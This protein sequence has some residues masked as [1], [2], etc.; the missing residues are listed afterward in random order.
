MTRIQNTP[1]LAIN[2]NRKLALSIAEAALD[3]IDTASIISSSISL[4]GNILR[5]QGESFDLAQFKKIKVIGFGKASCEAAHALEKILG[6]KI[7]QGVVVGLKSIKCDYIETFAGTHPTPAFQ[8]IEIGRKVFEMSTGSTEE[9]LVIVIVSGGGSSLLCWPEEECEQEVRLYNA[10]SKHGENINELNTIRKHISHLKGGGLAKILFPAT[11]IGLIFSDVPGNHFE[12]V[13]SGPTYKDTTTIADAKKLID[14]YNLGDFNLIETPK[15]D[16]FFK[17]VSNFVLVSNV[18]ALDAM[19]K[20]AE[21]LGFSVEILSSELY[22]EAKVVVQKIYEKRKSNTVIL[23]G[24]EPKVTGDKT[25]GSGGRCLFMGIN[26]LDTLAASPKQDSVFIFLASDGIDNSLSAGVV[27]DDDTLTKSVQQK[28]DRADHIRRF[29][30]YV[31]FEKTGDSIFTG[32][33]NANVSDLMILL[34]K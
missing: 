23:A 30:S 8:N 26:A 22:D 4:V 19:K 5:I 11:V 32:P 25:G 21:S 7:D 13:A 15:D 6:S 33:T 1:Q 24:G 14:T 10:F 2:E 16:M 20:K 28:L 17:K 29:D 31:F 9:D 27:V 34:T 3:A 18:T 12:N